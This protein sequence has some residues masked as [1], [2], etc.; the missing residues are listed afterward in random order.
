MVYSVRMSMEAA[1]KRYLHHVSSHVKLRVGWRTVPESDG[2]RERILF[3]GLQVNLTASAI[4]RSTA[5]FVVIAQTVSSGRAP[6]P[7]Q[8]NHRLVAVVAD[9]P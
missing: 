5:L 9:W 1:W 2:G 8:V 4:A 3:L 6:I 7:P